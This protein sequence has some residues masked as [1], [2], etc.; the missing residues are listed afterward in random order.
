MGKRENNKLWL[1]IQIAHPGALHKKTLFDNFGKFIEFKIAGDHEFLIRAGDSVNA[2]FL[3]EIIEMQD[4]GISKKPYK[5]FLRVI[6][7]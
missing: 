1:N 5:A 2:N 4:G 3:D 7:Q 6:S